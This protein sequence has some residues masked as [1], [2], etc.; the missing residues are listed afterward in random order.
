MK[1]IF[2][3]AL[4]EQPLPLPP[5]TA[6]GLTY[7]GPQGLLQTLE[8][9]L[10]LSGQPKDNDYLRIEEYRQA[11]RQYLEQRPEAF[12]AASFAA[13][14]FAT[15][16]NLLQR[17][18][19][20]L[21]AGWD[22]QPQ[23]DT[24]KRLLTL[25][26]VEHSLSQNQR[27]LSPGFADR[28]VQ[29]RQKLGKRH[30][31]ITEVEHVEPLHLLPPA[32]RLL[33][34]QLEEL[35]V[36][37]TAQPD[38]VIEGDSDLAQFQ[39][40][41]L[42]GGQQKIQ[43]QG[44]GSLLLLHGQRDS[45]LASYLA[46]LLRQNPGF[47]PALLIEDK[48]QVLGHALEL[49]GLPSLGLLSASLARPTL[50]VLKL[51][52]VFLWKPIDPYKI[53][54][55]VS[56]SVKPLERELAN[57]I[58][59]EMAQTPGIGSD[60]WRRMIARYFDEVEE[61]PDVERIR[62]QYNFWFS[63]PRYDISGRVPKGD[64]VSIFDYLSAWAK[65]CFEE[66]GSQNNSLLILHQQARRIKELLDALPEEWLTNLELERIVR[67]I[68]EPA[69][70]QLRK[71][72]CGFLPF[73]SQTGAVCGMLPELVWW[74]FTQ[75]EAEHFFSRWYKSEREYFDKLRIQLLS[76]STESQLQLWQRKRP[77]LHAG[78]RLF[79]IAPAFAD[80]QERLPHPLMGDLEAK[81]EGM[82]RISFDMEASKEHDTFQQLFQLPSYISLPARQLGQPK[83]F[84]HIRHH[85]DR[86]QQRETESFSSLR[87]LFYYPYQWV[88]RHKV[89][90][91]QTALL[92]IVKDHTLMGNLAHRFFERLLEQEQVHRWTQ[93]QVEAFIAEQ[94]ADLLEKEGA[95][96]LM[97]GREPERSSFV[98]K[99]KRAAWSLIRHLQENGWAVEATETP[100]EGELFGLNIKGRADLMLKR[101][102]ERAVLDL[103]WRGASR[104]EQ[105]IRNEE[106]LQLVLYASMAGEGK[107]WAHTAFFIMENGKIIA[108]NNKAFEGINGVV[109]DADFV[110]VNQR[111]L[112]RMEAT[113]R[114][115]M[116]QVERGEVEVRCS[117]TQQEIEEAYEETPLL[118]ILEMKTEDAPFDDYRT[119]INLLE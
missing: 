109:P 52:T 88:F 10:G 40:A 15:A 25:A 24:P 101:G 69:P 66:E 28:F 5:G 38:P 4:D 60:S 2:G 107:S 113:F 93:E 20:L 44:D 119:L 116:E 73:T 78:K 14:Q 39:R 98:Q 1:L 16:T 76:P 99:V 45:G 63:R 87:D 17:R 102:Q 49:E 9:Q 118:D 83:P 54:E 72:E 82:E 21:L 43:L 65:E 105:L 41:L 75:G 67:T 103:K 84:I 74:N 23:L 106:D 110:E 30:I 112:Q 117:Q 68:Y 61:H 35:G 94:E 91:R 47:R 90:L 97:Y 51:A 42:E 37:I 86:L 55:F 32:Y 36:N 114:W 80:G 95:V 53:M 11:L 12:F 50:Q 71:R 96:L 57:R 115:R 34:Q 46:Q 85:L 62:F 92:S 31:S 58:A 64:A 70:V 7:C 8:T 33:M 13:D 6:G 77:V 108:R 56:L 79:L 89:R 3:M 111:I 81:C 59:E 18:D 27:P 104:R 48:S 22:F 29:V 26:E 19:E 100:L